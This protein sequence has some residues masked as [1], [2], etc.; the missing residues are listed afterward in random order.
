MLADEKARD[1]QRNGIQQ[2]QRSVAYCSGL[3]LGGSCILDHCSSERKMEGQRL[4][5]NLQLGNHD[6]WYVTTLI[7]PDP[8]ANS[9]GN[10]ILATTT[11][12][13]PRYFAVFLIASGTLKPPIKGP[14]ADEI[15]IYSGPGLNI[16]WV[17]GNVANH[18]KRSAA[19]GLNQL[20]GNS[21]GAA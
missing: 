14:E 7:V 2:C 10:I 13:G 20:M 21:A 18:Y 1:Y 3:S 16:S 19:F 11:G 17:A 4:L 12:T 6:D 9:T 15:G 8:N 5:C